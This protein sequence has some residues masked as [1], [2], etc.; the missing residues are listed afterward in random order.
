MHAHLP[1]VAVL[2]AAL[3]RPHRPPL[4]GAALLL[5]N[6]SRIY[7][8]K[9]TPSFVKLLKLC[10]ID[11]SFD[12]NYSLLIAAVVLL[13]CCAAAELPTST[14]HSTAWS[15]VVIVV[16]MEFRA[17]F[18]IGIEFGEGL[19]INNL[20]NHILTVLWNTMDWSIIATS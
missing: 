17:N 9:F 8:V 14:L 1:C 15:A 3:H 18:G 6:L 20:H 13:C 10:C 12:A 19:N 2:L 11:N 16:R 7:S 4:L 5:V